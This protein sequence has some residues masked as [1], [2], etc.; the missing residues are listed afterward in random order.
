MVPQVLEHR[1]PLAML[2]AAAAG[3]FL[4]IA[5][6]AA[7]Q[8]AAGAEGE[9]DGGG[10]DAP[11]A[12]C[13]QAAHEAERAHALPSGLLVALALSE[14]GLHAYALNIAGRAHYPAD[15]AT[16]RRLMTQ[17][18]AEGQPVMAG[19][20]QV[21]WRVHVPSGADWPLDPRRSADW[22][23]RRLRA[24]YDST[25]SWAEALRRWNGGGAASQ[26]LVCRVRGKLQAI[27][28][29]SQLL[30]AEPCRE[31]LLA[32]ERRNGRALVEL[33]EA[34]GE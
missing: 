22:A 5:G 31:T 3:A 12:A 9:G 6:S 17:A 26:H 30:D 21:N 7:A 11:R 25:G 34:D 28:P 4:L 8:R 1:R 15:R 19:C 23:A 10:G 33:A 2:L 24:T 32:R 13:L 16:A 18:R 14:S 27:A 29:G 20:V